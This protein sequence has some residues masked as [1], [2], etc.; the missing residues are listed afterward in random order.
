VENYIE[1]YLPIK[2]QKAIGKN[3]RAVFEGK[4]YITEKYLAFEE[5][6]LKECNKT[7]LLDDG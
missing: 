4:Q 7:I 5:N 6:F 3:I 2:I 1:K